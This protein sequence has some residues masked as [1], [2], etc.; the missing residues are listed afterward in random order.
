MA[1]ERRVAR[2]PFSVDR[3]LAD[4]QA[5]FWTPQNIQ[6][7]WSGHSF[8]EPGDGNELS[9][10]LAEILIHLLEEKGESFLDFVTMADVYDAGQDAAATVMAVDLGQL[11]G[12][13]LGPGD[14]RPQRKTI[15][16]MLRP[17]EK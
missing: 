6:T 16:Q 1:L 8:D 15:T 11:V 14:W 7:F 9:Y 2:Y 5:G 10:S 3:E 17:A 12:G 13:F 4:R